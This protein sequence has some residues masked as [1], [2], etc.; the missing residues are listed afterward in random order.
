MVLLKEETFIAPKKDRNG[1]D[2]PLIL[3][4]QNRF[5]FFFV[6]MAFHFVTLFIVLKSIDF[7][8]FSFRVRDRSGNPFWAFTTK[9]I[10]T[11]SLSTNDSGR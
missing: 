5:Y 11:D 6:M 2:G 4:M 9:K 1:W 7:L 8:V 10:E 3:L